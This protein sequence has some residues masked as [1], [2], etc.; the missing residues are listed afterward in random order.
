MFLKQRMTAALGR[1]T[2]KQTVKQPMF[3]GG[4]CECKIPFS[5]PGAVSFVTVMATP[6]NQQLL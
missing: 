6:S 4:L 1:H 3:L 5:N 2:K